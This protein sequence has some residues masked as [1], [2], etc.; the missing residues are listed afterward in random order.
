MQVGIHWRGGMGSVDGLKLPAGGWGETALGQLDLHSSGRSQQSSVYMGW[1]PTGR[2][3]VAC[4]Y[5]QQAS[6]CWRCAAGF[7]AMLPV[8]LILGLHVFLL[9]S[10][11][12]GHAQIRWRGPMTPFPRSPCPR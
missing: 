4:G 12:A 5:S 10:A 3:M 1:K 8:C 7:N 11:E 6:S 2:A 9:A